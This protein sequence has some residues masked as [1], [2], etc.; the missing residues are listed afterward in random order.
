MRV[1]TKVKVGKAIQYLGN[2][3]EIA[4]EFGV[5]YKEYFSYTYYKDKKYM[6]YKIFYKDGSY[7]DILAGDYVFQGD[8]EDKP[9]VISIFDFEEYWEEAK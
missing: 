6:D 5:D 4:K 3:E 8:N 2:I 7:E 9:K 1:Q